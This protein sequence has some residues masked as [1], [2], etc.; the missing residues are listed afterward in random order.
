MPV[1]YYVALPFVRTEDGVAPGEAKEMPNGGAAIRR[2]EAMSR[3]PANSGAL[4]FRRSGDP[5]IGNSCSSAI[6][7][8]ELVVNIATA[9]DSL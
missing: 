8:L 1:T 2:A 3:D 6:R 5:N 9:R 7:S 4:A